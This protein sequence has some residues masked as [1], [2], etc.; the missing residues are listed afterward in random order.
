MKD[1]E[2]FEKIERLNRRIEKNKKT[3][4]RD[5]E[6][7]KSEELDTLIELNQKEE[8]KKGLK[9]YFTALLG[10]GVGLVFASL[11]ALVATFN[12]FVLNLGVFLTFGSIGIGCLVGSIYVRKVQKKR[13]NEIHNLKNNLSKIKE[14]LDKKEHILETLDSRRENWYKRLERDLK[15]SKKTVK[16]NLPV[17]DK[18]IL[19]NKNSNKN[20]DRDEEN[21]K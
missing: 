19:T 12:F 14:K 11:I 5:I 9:K 10:V 21:T 15:R 8:R 20:K 6:K 18:S 1:G 3:Q 7:L 13:Q 16:E 4:K 17:R 2:I